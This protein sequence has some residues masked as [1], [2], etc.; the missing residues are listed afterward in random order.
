MI[1]MAA[2]IPDDQLQGSVSAALGFIGWKRGVDR[3]GATSI[4]PIGIAVIA[5]NGAVTY[6]AACYRQSLESRLVI[7][8][9]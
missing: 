1:H 9:H 5:A 7:D 8:L 4:S 6:L 3:L 2:E